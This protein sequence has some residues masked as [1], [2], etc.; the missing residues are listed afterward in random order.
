MPR[1]CG[2]CGRPC[3]PGKRD[4]CP[5]R[6]ITVCVSCL[7]AEA[8]AFRAARQAAEPV[9]TGPRQA[10]RLDERLGRQLKTGVAT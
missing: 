4:W 5:V 1:P 2:L 6:K 3:E 9:V 7:E 10:S 8:A